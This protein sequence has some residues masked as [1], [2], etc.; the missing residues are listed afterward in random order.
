M[1]V[2]DKEAE[3]AKKMVGGGSGC[4]RTKWIYRG[5][6][7]ALVADPRLLCINVAVCCEWEKKMPR[8]FILFVK[9]L[10]MSLP[11]WKFQQVTDHLQCIAYLNGR[12]Q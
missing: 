7:H 1:L 2:L 5:W 3:W 9:L 8:M 11:S 6:W 4:R 12:S 10:F